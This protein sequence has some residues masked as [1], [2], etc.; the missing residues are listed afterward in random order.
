MHI[1]EEYT[2]VLQGSSGMLLQAFN[3]YPRMNIRKVFEGPLDFLE[4]LLTNT[5]GEPHTE[6][7]E[8]LLRLYDVRSEL[9]EISLELQASICC[10]RA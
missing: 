2:N 6:I 10:S 5:E 1:L 4:R 7:L 3:T 9:P 8:G